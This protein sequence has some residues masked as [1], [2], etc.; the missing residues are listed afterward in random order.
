MKRYA[1]VH[2][3]TDGSPPS[4][5]FVGETT[6]RQLCVSE[7]DP[8]QRLL[9]DYVTGALSLDSRLHPYVSVEMDSAGRWSARGVSW[10]VND[11]RC[12]FANAD[13]TDIQSAAVG[14]AAGLDGTSD[15]NASLEGAADP[16]YREP[17][18]HREGYVHFLGI[19]HP[20]TRHVDDPKTGKRSREPNPHRNAF[21]DKI[22]ELKKRCPL[23]I[24]LKPLE[25]IVV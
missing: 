17:H 4:L 13:G 20:K 25:N 16:V 22:S 19:Y 3:T 2:R 8:T 7:I 10:V 5:R 11:G 23:S 18:L 6:M 15:A 24:L 14:D 12:S 9:L 1:I 21:T